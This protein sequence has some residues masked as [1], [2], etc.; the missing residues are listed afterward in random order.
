MVNC[1]NGFRGMWHMHMP[2]EHLSPRTRRWHNPRWLKTQSASFKIPFYV[3]I[4]LLKFI[5]FTLTHLPFIFVASQR[6]TCPKAPSP[7]MLKNFN[8]YLGNSQRSPFASPAIPFSAWRPPE[9]APPTATPPDPGPGSPVPGLWAAAVASPAL[10]TPVDSWEV[11]FCVQTLD[12]HFERQHCG[13]KSTWP[14]MKGS[15]QHRNPAAEMPVLLIL[16]TGTHIRRIRKNRAKRRDY[17]RISSM[18]T[19][20]LK[21][22]INV[23]TI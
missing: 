20:A 23:W 4:K 7:N 3:T 1:G 5:H 21:L 12:W 9:V 14:S 8:R 16:V 18:I 10:V 17:S 13:L 6:H 2:H 11:A 15:F 19:K 22:S